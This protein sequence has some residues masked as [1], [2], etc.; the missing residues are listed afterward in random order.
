[1]SE[2]SDR[3]RALSIPPLSREREAELLRSYKE[4]G[5][6]RALDL[7]TR[8]HYK[9]VVQQAYRFG[10]ARGVEYP[11]FDDLIQ[12]GVEGLIHAANH[13][14]PGCDSSFLTYA[15]WWVYRMQQMLM[16][17]GR[18]VRA[19]SVKL[20]NS[21][22]FRVRRMTRDG[23]SR[24]EIVDAIPGNKKDAADFVYSVLGDDLSIDHESFD[25]LYADRSIPDLEEE[26]DH[27]DL[28]ARVMKSLRAL[29]P[30]DRNVVIRRIVYDEALQTIGDDLGLSRERVRQIYNAA[31]AKV[32]RLLGVDL[33]C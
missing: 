20:E 9:Y 26:I 29:K 24:D 21:W 31:L 32:R 28:I 4:S 16:L 3:L 19:G 22:L 2:L 27:R 25:S 30:R 5:D 6:Q 1:M 23:A 17:R 8:A 13:W 15:A 7:I 14:K 11:I 10:A 12:A 18:V 33:S